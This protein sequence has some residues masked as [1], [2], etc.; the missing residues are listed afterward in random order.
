MK[1]RTAFFQIWFGF[2]NWVG[3]GTGRRSGSYIGIENGL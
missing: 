1:V 2:S 3:S